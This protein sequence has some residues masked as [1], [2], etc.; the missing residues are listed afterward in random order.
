MTWHNFLLITLISV[1]STYSALANNG[2]GGILFLDFFILFKRRWNIN[3]KKNKIIHFSIRS[4][5]R[6]V[7]VWECRHSA[8]PFTSIHTLVCCLYRSRQRR[9]R[10]ERMAFYM[11]LSSSSLPY[12]R[13]SNKPQCE[14]RW[15][16]ELKGQNIAF[17]QKV[18]SILNYFYTLM[19]RL[20][21][22]CSCTTAQNTNR[23]LYYYRS[24]SMAVVYKTTYR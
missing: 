5:N 11:S 19:A 22:N 17:Y 24:I 1:A 10:K 18:W 21:G 15:R 6:C 20:L 13:V 4:A 3:N 7:C 12:L 8:T 14:K 23:T 16:E 2:P 9:H